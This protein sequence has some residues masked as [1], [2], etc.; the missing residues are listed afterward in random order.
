M[1]A[2]DAFPIRPA[3]YVAKVSG[4][5]ASPGAT[6]QELTDKVTCME[7]AWQDV[8]SLTGGRYQPAFPSSRVPGDLRMG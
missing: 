7:Q 5:L 3:G 4:I 8:V 6:R 2:I 1:E